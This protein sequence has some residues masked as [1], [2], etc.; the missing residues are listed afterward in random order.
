LASYVQVE[1]KIFYKYDDASAE[2][3]KQM[4]DEINA[5]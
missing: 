1:T 3:L 5:L 4:N 2:A